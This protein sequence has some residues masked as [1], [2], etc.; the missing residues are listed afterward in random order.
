MHLQRQSVC[1]CVCMCVSVG[2][3]SRGEEEKK[4]LT[5]KHSKIQQLAP[6]REGMGGERSQLSLAWKEAL[7]KSLG[8]CELNHRCSG[9]C[10]TAI[11][12][13]QRLWPRTV[14]L[15]YSEIHGG[16]SDKNPSWVVNH[17]FTKLQGL[18]REDWV[19]CVLC[20]L[21]L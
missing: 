7:D 12:R 18:V 8:V 19:I 14:W 5:I 4:R 15:Y 9:K 13:S 17:V 16:P 6:P 20:H 21:N 10:V 2:V 1:V 3:G 11:M